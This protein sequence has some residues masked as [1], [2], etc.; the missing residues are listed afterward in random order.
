MSWRSISGPDI[1]A[2]LQ[3]IFGFNLLGLANSKLL[4]L[5]CSFE[6]II[7]KINLIFLPIT[8]QSR[9]SRSEN[10]RPAEL[11]VSGTSG[12]KFK[13]FCG[14]WCACIFCSDWRRWTGVLTGEASFEVCCEDKDSCPSFWLC[15]SSLLGAGNKLEIQV[16]EFTG[17]SLAP[18][19]KEK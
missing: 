4:K 5:K 18:A 11:A 1:F 10:L 15:W 3:R 9:F 6:R 13:G 19:W 2:S 8:S 16:L 17:P 12:S 14:L 7:K